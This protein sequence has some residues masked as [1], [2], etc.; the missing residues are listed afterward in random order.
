L[1]SKLR[2][3]GGAVV[4]AALAVPS[5]GQAAK[6]RPS[7]PCTQAEKTTIYRAHGGLRTTFHAPTHSPKADKIFPIRMTV[8]TS[9]GK[10]VSGGHVFYQFL[11]QG[12]V[13]ACRNVGKPGVPYLRKGVFTD[14]LAWPQR[15]V[16]YE[17]TLRLVVRAKSALANVDYKIKVRK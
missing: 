15:A 6:P 1:I 14:D 13:V 9:A 16:G 12:Q 7:K 17:L 11:F 10:P 5:G 3:A 2:L 4:V 8:K